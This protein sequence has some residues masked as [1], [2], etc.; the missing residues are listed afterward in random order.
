MLGPEH[1]TLF[2]GPTCLRTRVGSNLGLTFSGALAIGVG[3]I[4]G[5][6]L[7]G[8]VIRI[9]AVSL[10]SLWALPDGRGIYGI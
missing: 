9:V 6:A 8:K 4:L 1:S 5:K 7:L 10:F 2:V 3:A